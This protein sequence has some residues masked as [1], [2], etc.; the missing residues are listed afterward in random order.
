[1][2]YANGIISI[3]TNTTPHQGVSIADVQ[4]ALGRGTGDLGLLC[5]DQEWYSDTNQNE[6]LRR[7]NKINKWAKYKPY[8]SSSLVSTDSGDEGRIAKHYGLSVDAFESLGSPSTANSFLAKLVA[9]EL[10][11][12]YLPPRGKG[13]G[14]AGANEWFR[15]LDFNGYNHNAEAPV[16]DV[17]TG[18][19][20]SANGD[21]SINWDLNTT[22]ATG[23]ITLGDLYIGNTALTSYYLGVLLYQSGS[24]YGTTYHIV[25]ST[26]TLGQGDVTIQLTNAT[27]LAG[28]WEV[29][30]F[31]SSVQIAFDASLTTG[32]YVSAGWGKMGEQITFRL[33]SDSLSV[34]VY[35][36]WNATHTAFSYFIEAY[37]DDS[38]SKTV[39]PTIH[40]RR[41]Q[42]ASTE[43]VSENDID[44]WTFG[45][46]TVAAHDSYST[47]EHPATRSLI[48]GHT[49]SD[50]YIYWLGAA[51]TN[52]G[53]HFVQ[54]ED[55]EQRQ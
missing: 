55:T 38:V 8:R 27:A 10:D 26:T 28:T 12:V 54:M 51:V 40:L 16:G 47:A 35:G 29:Y 22:P 1:M 3:N 9:G 25:T 20:I 52:Y 30:P 23:S 41:N 6:A 33:V 42:S 14:T 37:N 49:Y 34:Y 19:P 53:T 50:A 24:I 46:I 11:W 45:S 18:I 2:P 43:P 31:F 13:G 39:T 48:A 32:S 21:A 15:L 17:I 44:S 5:S 36:T 7:A 4:K